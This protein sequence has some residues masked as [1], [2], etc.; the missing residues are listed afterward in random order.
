M[1]FYMVKAADEATLFG[2]LGTLG[3]AGWQ[4]ISVVH[5]PHYEDVVM[6]K[7]PYWTAWLQLEVH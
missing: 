6:R 5:V 4:L 3:D 7:A 1:L 2:E